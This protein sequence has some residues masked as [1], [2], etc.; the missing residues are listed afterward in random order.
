VNVDKF[1]EFISYRDAIKEQENILKEM[2]EQCDNLEYELT[3]EMIA[4]EMQSVDICG[5]KIYAVN[6]EIYSIKPETK[7]EFIDLI[8]E[9][10]FGEIVKTDINYQTLNAWVKE[11]KEEGD[12]SW[13]EDKVNLFEKM[14]L[15]VRK[16]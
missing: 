10:G 13:F 4:D 16:S 7:K 6:K 5:R 11:R 14:S 3:Q 2:K 12:I 9:K 8:T 1:K 15:S